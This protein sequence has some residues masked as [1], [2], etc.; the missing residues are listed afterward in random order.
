[1]QNTGITLGILDILAMI[2]W[3]IF[4]DSWDCVG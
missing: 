4:F 1:M 3:G 2:F